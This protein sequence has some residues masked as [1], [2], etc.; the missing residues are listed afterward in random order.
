MELALLKRV[1]LAYRSATGGNKKKQNLAGL[2]DDEF[3]EIKIE[4][5]SHELMESIQKARTA[6]EWS[7]AQLAKVVMVKPHIITDIENGEAA[8]NPDLINKIEKALGV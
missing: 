7:Q 1:S 2:R 8:Y 3:E 6:K 4:K 5:V